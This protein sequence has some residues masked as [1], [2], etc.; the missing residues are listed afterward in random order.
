MIM[1]SGENMSPASS[2]QGADANGNGA[3]DSLNVA[4]ATQGLMSQGVVPT[5]GVVGVNVSNA[6]P[7]QPELLTAAQA[8]AFMMD[9]MRQLQERMLSMASAIGNAADVSGA[10]GFLRDFASD[11]GRMQARLAGINVQE[12]AVEQVAPVVAENLPRVTVVPTPVAP[13]SAA[14]VPTVADPVAI[15][16]VAPPVEVV[17][18]TVAPVDPVM[19]A[20]SAAPVTIAPHVPTVGV[21]AAVPTVTTQVHPAAAMTVAATMLPHGNPSPVALG[22]TAT[23]TVADTVSTMQIC[24]APQ[25]SLSNI[26]LPAMPT[27]ALHADPVPWLT[28]LRA[29]LNLYNLT[30]AAR[31]NVA[32]S[33]LTPEV[34]NVWAHAFPAGIACTFDEFC[35][36]LASNFGKHDADDEIIRKLQSL[37]QRGKIAAY[38]AEFLALW[39]KLQ[40]KPEELLQIKWFR[41]GLQQR[42]H[43]ATLY[44][45]N[46]ADWTSFSRLQAAVLRA[47]AR[48][49]SHT[50]HYRETDP[51]RSERRM[52]PGHAP[53]PGG[54]S[55]RRG[56]R[57]GRRGGPSGHASSHGS[58]PRPAG[59]PPGSGMKRPRD[60]NV[61]QCFNCSDFGH[62]A[63]VCTKPRRGGRTGVP[64]GQRPHG[65]GFVHHSGQAG[66]S[67]APRQGNA[68][69]R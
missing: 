57:G 47:D 61:V 60:G 32:V 39:N 44:D 14:P 18:P 33:L 58:V 63:N 29:R 12:E 65:A 46:N 68:P 62:K 6:S 31:V 27:F 4:N 28:G 21:P 3:N 52:I 22:R 16:D 13:V 25:S 69:T 1:T 23:H 35:E 24:Q 37:R 66:P 53:H 41:Q 9:S 40:N 17:V 50:S 2:A 26:T 30:D 48:I 67:S 56:F 8:L 19:A 42:V 43:D 10:R 11:A 54:S 45:E 5:V 36:W 64:S 34:Q 20:T 15:S 55:Q 7:A 51:V 38:C 59:A 49:H